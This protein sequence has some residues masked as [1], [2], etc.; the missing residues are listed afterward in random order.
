[1]LSVVVA[2]A[3]GVD[4]QTGITHLVPTLTALL[5][6]KIERACRQGNDPGSRKHCSPL[7]LTGK[8]TLTLFVLC[9][10]LKTT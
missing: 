7:T 5:S 4:P 2:L 6:W 8:S 1:M 10:K 9:R 3:A